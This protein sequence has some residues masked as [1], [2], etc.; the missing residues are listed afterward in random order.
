MEE[1]ALEFARKAHAEQFRKYSNEP[2]IVHPIRVAELVK[3][4]SHS[5]DMVCAAYLHDVV[6]DTPVSIDEI[7]AEFGQGIGDL[8]DELTDEFLKIN[9]PHLN[10]S[11]R[12]Q[13][14]VERQAGMS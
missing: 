7:H 10:R 1:E 3:T 4:V 12:K 6:E 9:Y 13:R 14:E 5:H 8:V 11:S 2:Y